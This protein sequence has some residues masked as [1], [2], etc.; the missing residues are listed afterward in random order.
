VSVSGWIP[1]A[2]SVAE[3]LAPQIAERVARYEVQAALLIPASRLCHQTLGIMA[4]RLKK[5]TFRR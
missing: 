4:R 3:Q 5:R 1:N 2:Q